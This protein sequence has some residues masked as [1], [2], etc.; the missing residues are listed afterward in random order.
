MIYTSI[1]KFI[2][3]FDFIIAGVAAL[4]VGAY[5][6]EFSHWFV[7][8]IGETDPKMEWGYLLIPSGVNHG[9][10]ET[11]DPTFIRLSGASIFIWIIPGLISLV[12]LSFEFT[13]IRMFLSLTPIVTI[14][15]TTESDIVAI[16]EPERFRRMWIN[17]EFQRNAVFLPNWL[18]MDWL[19]DI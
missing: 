7:G 14:L 8:W 10:I 17:N 3:S 16:R 2:P 15:M 19:P 12:Y 9:N 5:L 18:D 4:V 1:I 6:H 13:P 11:M